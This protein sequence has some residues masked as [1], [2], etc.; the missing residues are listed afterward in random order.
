M[1]IYGQIITGA[2]VRDAVEQHVRTWTLGYLGEVAAQAGFPRNYLPDFRAYTSDIQLEN[3]LTDEQMP[4]LLVV[5][6][7]LSS[8]PV[9]RGDGTWKTTW[10][11]NLTVVVSARD[12]MSTLRNVELYTAAVRSAVMQQ[13]SLGG[14]A[15]G[16]NWL[17]ESYDAL[18]LEQAPNIGAGIVSLEV[19]VGPVVDSTKGP[20]TPPAAPLAEPPANW[21]VFQTSDLETQG[22]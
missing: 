7:G 4:C 8:P 20:I 22:V 21:G 12:R 2:D 13:P 16:C 5:S 18:R 19:E 10:T 17:D 6:P 1:N 3:G 9:K 11:I 15:L 14:F